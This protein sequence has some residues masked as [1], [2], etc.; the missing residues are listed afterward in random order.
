MDSSFPRIIQYKWIANYTIFFGQ[1]DKLSQVMIN[2]KLYSPRIIF[3]ILKNEANYIL[4]ISEICVT[5]KI[6][7]KVV[8]NVVK[9]KVTQIAEKT[10]FKGSS[11]EILNHNLLS[12]RSNQKGASFYEAKMFTAE[13]GTGDLFVKLTATVANDSIP[14]GYLYG[15]VNNDKLAASIR[16]NSTGEK[17]DDDRVLKQTTKKDG[18]LRTRIRSASWIYYAK[19]MK[20][21]DPLPVVKIVITSEANYDN[22]IDWQD[23]AI[24]FRNIINNPVGGDKIP[25]LVVQ[26][27]P[28]N[29]ASQAT[30]PFTKTL[31]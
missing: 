10:A 5:V 13:K 24:A 20:T 4:D 11:F 31:D 25:N 12:I 14:K 17:S 28:M 27:I 8:A 19:R 18:N 1:D 29:F 23:G 9:Y 7:I 3:S 30:N 6:Q 16:S 15:I 21:T 2:G 26:R 22:K